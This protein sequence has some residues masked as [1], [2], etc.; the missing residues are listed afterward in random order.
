MRL[1]RDAASHESRI[2]LAAIVTI[3][4]VTGSAILLMGLHYYMPRNAITR[5]VLA[6]PF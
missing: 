5:F 3:M 6:T 1:R 4:I 2:C